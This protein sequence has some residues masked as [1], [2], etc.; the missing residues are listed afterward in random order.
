MRAAGLEH[1]NN[2]LT[3]SPFR[4]CTR[5]ASNWKARKSG[6]FLLPTTDVCATANDSSHEGLYDELSALHSS[7][8][9]VRVRR[10]SG[11]RLFFRTA[12]QTSNV[13]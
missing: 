3:T 6:I 2:S 7:E 1:Q 10:A 8:I 9:I 11:F 5:A 4:Q 12:R 13:Q